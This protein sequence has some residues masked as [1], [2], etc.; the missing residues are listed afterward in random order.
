MDYLGP[1]HVELTNVMNKLIDKTL[2]IWL[3]YTHTYTHKYICVVCVCVC[4]CV[5]VNIGRR[6]GQY[7]IDKVT[8]YIELFKHVTH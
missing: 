6:K 3:V 8:S 4:V 5:W 1:K 2:C 7:E